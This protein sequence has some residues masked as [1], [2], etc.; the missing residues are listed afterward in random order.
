MQQLL[1]VLQGPLTLF[2]FSLDTFTQVWLL[3]GGGTKSLGDKAK[4]LITF[5]GPREEQ[6][7]LPPYWATWEGEHGSRIGGRGRSRLQSLLGVLQESQ[8]RTDQQFRIGYLNN[9]QL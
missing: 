8:G 6:G 3:G 7:G 5:M 2:R 4:Q 1:A 9:Q